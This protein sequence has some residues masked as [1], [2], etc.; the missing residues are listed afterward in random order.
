MTTVKTNSTCS[1]HIMFVVLVLLLASKTLLSASNIINVT[2]Y[3]I[4]L[5]YL[6]IYIN[7]MCAVHKLCFI[8]C[9]NK[10]TISK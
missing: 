5:I 10:Y 8:Y 6:Y 3:I 9:I 7:I 1:I 4:C 2:M